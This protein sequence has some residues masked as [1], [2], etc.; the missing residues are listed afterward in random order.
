ME[1][2]N[3]S[4]LRI[5][6]PDKM[7]LIR[8]GFVRNVLAALAGVRGGFSIEY[9]LPIR[10]T[11]AGSATLAFRLLWARSRYGVRFGIGADGERKVIRDR[12]NGEHAH[13]SPPT[14][15]GA[16]RLISSWPNT[17]RRSTI[18]RRRSANPNRKRPTASR[19]ASA[20]G[21]RAG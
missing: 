3:F 4:L 20:S 13:D 12:W 15:F 18:R 10:R 7:D 21:L 16:A 9:D 6:P 8:A 19:K 14:A 11:R 5:P 2:N 1:C 17:I